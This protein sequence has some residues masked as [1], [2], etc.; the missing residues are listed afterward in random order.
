[1]L[2]KDASRTKYESVSLAITVLEMP[3]VSIV[4]SLE[5]LWAIQ[6]E[7]R[8]PLD[9]DARSRDTFPRLGPSTE[10]TRDS[11][12]RSRNRATS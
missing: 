6:L 3:T 1:M 5:P 7:R 12:T 2:L 10:T 4:K 11:E 8:A 9:R